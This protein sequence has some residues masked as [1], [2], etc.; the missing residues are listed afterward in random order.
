MKQIKRLMVVMLC[1][2][3]SIA[4]T[5]QVSAKEE[6]DV[7]KDE[8]IYVI[9]D[10]AGKSKDITVSEWLHSDGGF[11]N[12]VDTTNLKDIKSLN[13]DDEIIVKDNKITFNTDKE[14]IYYEGKSDKE[15]PFDL[16]IK[17]YLDNKEVNASEL[18]NKT[19]H[20]KIEIKVNNYLNDGAILPLIMMTDLKTDEFKNV[21]VNSGDVISDGINQMVV[22]ASVLGIDDIKNQIDIDDLDKLVNDH[23]IIECDATDMSVPS[24]MGASAN[25]DELS[26]SD[27]NIDTNAF[28]DDINRLKDATG[29]IVDG[30]TKLK[31]ANIELSSKMNEFKSKIEEFKKGTDSLNENTIKIKDGMATLD[32][33]VDTLVKGL[34]SLMKVFDA[35]SD[36]EK[37]QA[38]A[39]SK[40]LIANLKSSKEQLEAM[41]PMLNEAANKLAN[42]DVIIKNSVNDEVLNGAFAKY[43][44]VLTKGMAD[45]ISAK[46]NETN[47][48]PS[49]LI[50]QENYA[51]VVG[52]LMSAGMDQET[53]TQMVGS[54]INT[55][56]LGAI[57]TGL[58][59]QISGAIT[60]DQTKALVIGGATTTTKVIID[61]LASKLKETMTNEMAGMNNALE[62][63]NKMI[64]DMTNKINSLNALLA[65]L[66]M[67]A[68][69]AN[70][71][72]MLENKASLNAL[73]QGSKTLKEGTDA[74]SKGTTK[75]ASSTNDILTATN[76]FNGAINTLKEKTKELNDG[77]IK[78]SKE[79]IDVLD[80]KLNELLDKF[81]NIKNSLDKISN[82]D[83]MYTN[84]G[85]VSDGT[86]SKVKIIFKT[87]EIAKE[88]ETKTVTTEESQKLGFFDRVT[89]LFK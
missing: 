67:E 16:D 58:S 8:S 50:N 60:S 84:Y 20:L 2:S 43:A 42:V 85:L 14:D 39:I 48:D 44:D 37:A 68:L 69:E 1:L 9:F 15:L 35:L 6:E 24:I 49:T 3:I 88:V 55:E 73:I 54:I 18:S 71:K 47:I 19:G 10:E 22:M 21:K 46:I 17:Y 32:K 34:N 31:D 45:T 57:K 28:K 7:T 36:E 77:T 70:L 80:S 89:N 13:S 72:A 5:L 11:N 74:L 51:K 82:K 62:G 26:L 78:F 66:D 41:K 53:A 56:A 27:F 12:Y 52:A 65:K 76:S 40:E 30:T 87:N 33:G 64:D 83:N 23:F 38:L 81:S 86:T 63:A 79:G 59:A 4:C 75:I 25:S 61:T 29:E